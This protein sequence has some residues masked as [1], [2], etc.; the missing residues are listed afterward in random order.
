[1]LKSFYACSSAVLVLV[2]LAFARWRPAALPYRRWPFFRRTPVH[3]PARHLANS[4]A[5]SRGLFGGMGGM[6]G[7][8]SRR[9]PARL[10]ALLAAASMAAASSTSSLSAVSFSSRSSLFS[11]RR[12]ATQ[13]A[14]QPNAGGFDSLRSTPGSDSTHQGTAAPPKRQGRLDWEALTTRLPASSP[15]IRMNPKKPAASDEEELLRQVKA[16]YTR[17]NNAWDKRD[18]FDIAQFSTQQVLN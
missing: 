14:G 15:C 12:A 17:L 6:L 1:M 13:G 10:A 2:M 3:E 11:R 5:P 4:A 8:P 7:G 18:L 16:A 9:Q